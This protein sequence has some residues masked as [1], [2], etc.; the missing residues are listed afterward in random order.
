MWQSI[1]ERRRW[2]LVVALVALAL[3]AINVWWVHTYRR[4][5]PFSVDEA[6]YTTIALVDY[7][8]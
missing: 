7:E 4:G 8:T 1:S 2:A 3:A 6:A 5:Y